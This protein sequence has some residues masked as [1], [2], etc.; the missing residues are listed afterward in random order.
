MYKSLFLFLIV[1]L[2]SSFSISAQKEG[3]IS[4]KI[5]DSKSQKP[6][7]FSTITIFSQIDS[8]VITGDA[9]DFNGVFK[10]RM[11]YGDYF[12]KVDFIS[13]QSVLIPPFSLN[14]QNA[15]YDLKSIAMDFNSSTL[16][17]IEVLSTKGEV[18]MSLDKQVYNVGKDIT[19]AGGNAVDILNNVPSVAVDPES[20]VTLRGSRGVQILVD[21]KPSSLVGG[22][23]GDG[24]R[25][26]S[27][28]L[29]DRIEVIT[30]PSAKYQAEGTGGIINI[31]LKKKRK[32]GLNGSADVTV[33]YPDIYGA[34]LNLNWRKK[35]FNFFTN[36]GL[37]F[38]KYHGGGFTYQEFKGDTL[39]II[40]LQRDH[41]IGG[42]WGN[43]KLGADYY[44]NKNNILTTAFSYQAGEDNDEINLEYFN[45]IFDINNPTSISTR[46][47]NT[48][49]QE[50]NLEYSL[51]YN[52]KLG[53]KGHELE[54]DLRFQDNLGEDDSELI[55]QYFNADFQP[56]GVNDLKHRSENTEGERILMTSLDYTYP[57]SK[58]KKI[59]VGYHGSFR[60]I[61]NDFLVEE[62]NDIIWVE[63]P[64]FSNDF[65]YDENIYGVYGSFKNKYK[66]F[67]YQ[68]G[69]RLEYT[70][71]VTTLLETN[72]ENPRD[73]LN[74]FPS[75]KIGFDLAKNNAIQ[76]SYSRRIR[77]PTFNDLNPFFTFADPQ[78]QFQGNPNLNPEYTDSYELKHIKYFDK[79]SFSTALFY[80]NRTDVITRIIEQING[81]TTLLKTQNLLSRDDLGLD[82]TGSLKATKW[83]NLNASALFF[84]LAF[85]GTNLDPDYKNENYTWQTRLSARIA[86]KKKTTLQLRYSYRGDQARAQGTSFGRGALNVGINRMFWNKKGRLT[87]NVTDLFNTQVITGQYET[88]TLFGQT[89]F[90]WTFRT[91]RL[92]FYYKF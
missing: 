90:R 61:R 35:K 45:F 40:D 4:G 69:A 76:L 49:K 87:F 48:T 89:N 44:F 26:L 16:K 30:N 80:R 71:V 10:M 77:R 54:M 33:G 51:T 34:S 9:A 6:L 31:V 28:S 65:Q 29:I 20:G 92:N 38:Q 39:K 47:D 32:T 70:D 11:P 57:I 85:D 53:K 12:A 1:F 78:N 37:D 64:Q 81:D 14:E 86:I 18:Q 50:N 15:T 42:L 84:R 52:R 62:F 55:Q 56:N 91:V 79:G 73:Y 82:L 25:R 22:T 88:D 60:Q 66:K 36:V 3:L 46:L 8:T 67:S 83:L 63:L 17:D 13:Y 19:S 23:G 59:E 24:L 68:L 7:E 43:V 41:E 75:A 2:L 72:E 5:I 58:E 27:A 21:G 74:L